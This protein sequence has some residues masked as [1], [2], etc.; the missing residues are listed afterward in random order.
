M[1]AVTNI[2]TNSASKEG[3]IHNVNDGEKKRRVRGVVEFDDAVAQGDRLIEIKSQCGHGEWS[4]VV[5]EE[6]VLEKSQI[7]KYMSVARNKEFLAKGQS[8]G[9]LTLESAS[10]LITQKNKV[11]K[12]AKLKAEGKPIPV[13]KPKK[14]KTL[15]EVGFDAPPTNERVL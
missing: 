7:K 5:N 15:K 10:K 11:E 14:K 6:L 4:K 8:T 2:N 12:E 1:N 9:F 3:L 13:K